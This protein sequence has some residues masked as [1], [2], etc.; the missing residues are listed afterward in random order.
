[1]KNGEQAR[2]KMVKDDQI[3]HDGIEVMRRM[4]LFFEQVLNVEDIEE[5]N[6]NIGNRRMCPSRNECERVG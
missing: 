3:L 6:I 4:A 5:G 1:M 2:D